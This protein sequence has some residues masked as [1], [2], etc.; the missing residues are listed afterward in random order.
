VFDWESVN[1]QL[2][3]DGTPFRLPQLLDQQLG[4]WGLD[5]RGLRR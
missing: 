2:V 4:T 3:I 1:S 5:R